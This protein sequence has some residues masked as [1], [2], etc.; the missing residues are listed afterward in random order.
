M[1]LGGAG[2]LLVLIAGSALDGADMMIPGVLVAVGAA[3]M[4]VASLR[5]A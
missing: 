2:F 3:M 1:M 4:A 5:R